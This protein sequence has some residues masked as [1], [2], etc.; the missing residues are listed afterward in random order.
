MAQLTTPFTGIQ[1]E[2]VPPLE[3]GDHLDQKTFHERYEAMPEGFRAELIGG[4]VYVPSPLKYR[5][6]RHHSLVM[7][8]LNVFE[9]ATPGVEV[10]DGTT[11]ILGDESEPQP[12]AMVIISPRAG[13]QTHLDE[14]DYV[15]GPPELVVE[16][17]SSS[18]SYDLYE[19]KRD[20]EQ[21]GVREY[22]VVV[23]RSQTIRWF[24]RRGEPF[25]EFETSDA[26]YRS[27]LLPGLWLDPQ[28]LFAKDAKKL[29]A[30][31][32][33]GLATQEHEAFVQLLNQRMQA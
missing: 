14:D 8:W 26:I 4:K 31:L 10:L 20:Y 28:A 15:T 2:T 5:H 30:T 12:D 6:G 13:G 7:G 17:A 22:L 11:V 21:L 32:S 33:R 29:L 23:V 19:K 24:A 1:N 16:V 9:A 27:E 25:V 18:E 3:A